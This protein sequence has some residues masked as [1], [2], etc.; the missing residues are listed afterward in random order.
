MNDKAKF[1]IGAAIFLGIALFPVW[2]NL[3]SGKADGAPE[4]IVKTG[5]MPGK[6]KCVMAAEY[7]STSHMFILRD[8]RETV[9]RTGDRKF[10]A[11]DG[12]Q[13]QRSLTD[14]C[15][16]CHSNKSSF[17]DRCHDYA[18]VQPDCWN[19]HVVPREEAR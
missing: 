8:W 3:A 13:F 14:T 1:C 17:C 4:I 10:T 9:V 12:R 18:A 2:H 7:M 19:C 5:N 15:L 16:D 6:D 11:F